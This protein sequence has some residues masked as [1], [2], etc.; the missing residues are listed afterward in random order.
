MTKK[1]EKSWQD[2]VSPDD[3]PQLKWMYTELLPQLASSTQAFSE[4]D[5]ISLYEDWNCPTWLEYYNNAFGLL[6]DAVRGIAAKEPLSN[7]PSTTLNNDRSI[8]PRKLIGEPEEV[9]AE[10]KKLDPETL[11]RLATKMLPLRLSAFA[12]ARQLTCV[13]RH[14]TTVQVL[15]EELRE[16]DEE[17]SDAAMVDLLAIDPSFVELPEIQRRIRIAV[18]TTDNTFLA[19]L[20]SA[21]Q[22]SCESQDLHKHLDDLAIVLAWG[23]GFEQ[24]GVEQFGFFLREIGMTRFQETSSLQR[25]LNRLGISTKK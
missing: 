16:E 11:W 8:D 15:I 1:K 9:I 14:S 18:L 10:F 13:G 4:E 23:L 24:V 7:K 17:K 3:I 2:I 6:L 22:Y 25:K 21:I 12:A 19:N 5:D 20:G